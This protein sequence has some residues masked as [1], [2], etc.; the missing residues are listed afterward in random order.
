MKTIASLLIMC[1]VHNSVASAYLATSVLFLTPFSAIADAFID[2]ARCEQVHPD[3]STAGLWPDFRG[4]YWAS[5]IAGTE[6]Y[7]VGI[8]QFANSRK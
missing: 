7:V 3:L 4:A 5:N 8:G 2:Q 6:Y 1:L